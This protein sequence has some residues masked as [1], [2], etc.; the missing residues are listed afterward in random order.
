MDNGPILY[1][2]TVD[3][4]P[5]ELVTKLETKYDITVQ[6][7]LCKVI[8]DYLEGKIE[9]KIQDITKATYTERYQEYRPIY[10]NFEKSIDIYNKIIGYPRVWPIDFCFTF[11]NDKKIFIKN[12]KLIEFKNDDLI[13]NNKKKNKNKVFKN[14]KIEND[15]NIIKRGQIYN[16]KKILENKENGCFQR[17]GIYVFI[18]SFENIFKITLF[19]DVDIKTSFELF[20]INEG[21]FHNELPQHFSIQP[22]DIEAS[23]ES[24]IN[25]FNVF[26]FLF[27][28]NMD[29][30]NKV[31][32]K[33]VYISS[34]FNRIERINEKYQKK[35]INLDF[36]K[37]FLHIEK[38]LV[39]KKLLNEEIKDL[40]NETHLFIKYS[41]LFYNL[42]LNTIKKKK[43]ELELAF[44]KILEYRN[45][46]SLIFLHI[47][48]NTLQI[49]ISNENFEFLNNVLTLFNIYNDLKKFKNNYEYF[50][51]NIY[52]NSKCSNSFN[53]IICYTL[54]Y[55]KEIGYKMI[56]NIF[57][58]LLLKVK[59]SQFNTSEFNLYLKSILDNEIIFPNTFQELLKKNNLN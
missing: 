15:K 42:S 44:L 16:I 52:D 26:Q 41:N 53:I 46:K 36:E 45:S 56:K 7:Y 30:F 5:D 43:E 48:L 33:L 10:W 11:L 29:S 47:F 34:Y 9:P 51:N 31:F 24:L 25:L 40:L 57:N 38:H 20:S 8:F 2:H 1:Q 23:N 58:D 18:K 27:I 13:I 37:H 12:A 14:E 6:T 35:R 21:Q 28:N 39:N 50:H 4:N 17:K 19:K 22:N 55:G 49:N 32:P 59:I 54:F 3:I